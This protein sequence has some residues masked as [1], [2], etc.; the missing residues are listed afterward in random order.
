MD[1]EDVNAIIGPLAVSRSN[2]GSIHCTRCID[3]FMFGI[4]YDIA[5]WYYASR[6]VSFI[7]VVPHVI[8]VALCSSSRV[9][10]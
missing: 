5:L 8:M 4:V 2:G 9:K 10:S 3:V 7:N 6:A 1:G